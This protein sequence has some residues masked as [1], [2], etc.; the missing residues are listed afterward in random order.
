MTDWR[1]ILVQVCPHAHGAVVAMIADRADEQF[2]RWKIDTAARQQVP[3]KAVF[4]HNIVP[5]RAENGTLLVATNDPFNLTM[6]ESIR[7]VT[8]SRVQLALCTEADIAKALKRYYGVGA[9]T[10]D[11]L[12]QKNVLD[13]DDIAEATK[14]AKDDLEGGDQGR[15][16][17]HADDRLPLRRQDVLYGFHEYLH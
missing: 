8:K 2:A 11:E 5:M 1:R 17:V 4:Q 7:L 12:M 3:T 10:L 16:G 13:I 14:D 15:V 9:E 6:V